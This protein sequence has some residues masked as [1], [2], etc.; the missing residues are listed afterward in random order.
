M[1]KSRTYVILHGFGT[2]AGRGGH[3]HE[4]YVYAGY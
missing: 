1:N 2:V 3:V 4:S